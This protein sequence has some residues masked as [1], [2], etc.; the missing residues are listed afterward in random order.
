MAAHVQRVARPLCE[1]R[2]DVPADLSA[3][4]QQM[5][6]KS[7][8]DR[9][10]TPGDVAR[11]L[12]AAVSTPKNQPVTAGM[13][14]AETGV[15]EEILSESDAAGSMRK[16]RSRRSALLFKLLR[17]T[18]I[19]AALLLAVA[20]PAVFIVLPEKTREGGTVALTIDQPDSEVFLDGRSVAPKFV[21][22]GKPVVIPSSA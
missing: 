8:A 5:L 9:P 4:V 21:P 11:T 18:V 7:P 22:K 15:W 6:A 20:V 2:P 1:V 14:Q 10:Q 19:A 17:R 13:N 3:L 12:Q 16:R